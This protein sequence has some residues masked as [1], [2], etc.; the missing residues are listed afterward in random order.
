MPWRGNTTTYN[1]DGIRTS[2]T[3][4]GMKHE[5]LLNGS[6]I[7]SETWIEGGVEHLLV[8]LYDEKGAPIGLKYRTGAYATGIFD[9]FFFE[10]NLQGDT[11]E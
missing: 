2:K 8:Y 4:N 9:Y 11:I 10:K 7:V 3:I 1:A 6:Q 5:Y